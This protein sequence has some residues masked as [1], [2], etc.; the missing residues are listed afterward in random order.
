MTV[1]ARLTRVNLLETTLS[2]SQWPDFAETGQGRCSSRF[3]FSASPSG[4]L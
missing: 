4:A 3:W 2:L 1:A